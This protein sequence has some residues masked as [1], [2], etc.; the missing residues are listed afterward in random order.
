M[1]FE[2]PQYSMTFDDSSEQVIKSTDPALNDLTQKVL[3]AMNPAPTITEMPDTYVKLPAGVLIKDELVQD[4]E[5][6]ELTGKDEEIL[7]KAKNS[8]NPA[9]YVN[10]LLECGVVSVGDKKANQ[11]LLSSLIQG[12]LDALLMGIRRATFGDTFEVFGVVCTSCNQSNDITLNLKDIP[13]KE[14]EDPTKREYEVELRRG[15][16]A[17]VKFPTGSV[18]NEIFKQQRTIPEMNSLTLAE[19]VLGFLEPDGSYR[20]SNGLADVKSLGLGDRKIL[21]DYI[22]DN[23]PGPR[24]DQV[25]AQCSGCESE[26]AV[27]LNVGILFREL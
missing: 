7:A 8:N 25:T 1:E 6:R 15:R 24:Y 13:V 26:V 18:Q 19:C 27:P 14:L 12:D 3:K 20:P 23:Q 4:A 22:Y 11:S 21:Q 2:L 10:T 9:K 17:V 16:K 5:V